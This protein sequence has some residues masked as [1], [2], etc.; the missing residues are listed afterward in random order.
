MPEVK[1]GYSGINPYVEI[2]FFLNEEGEKYTIKFPMSKMW[3][4]EII[5]EIEKVAEE[6]K[7][8]AEKHLHENDRKMMIHC[9]DIY[10]KL[11]E[12]GKGLR[13]DAEMN[14]ESIRWDKASE[15]L[16]KQSVV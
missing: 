15:G 11:M 6:E 1:I 8:K 10:L 5:C 14:S 9:Y 2:N 3:Y 4:K 12:I 13:R 7:N 16:K